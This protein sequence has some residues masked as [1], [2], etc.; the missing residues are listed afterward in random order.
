MQTLIFSFI[1]FLLG[2]GIAAMVAFFLLRRE[3]E[4]HELL[5]TREREFAA[6]TLAEQ[7]RRE[8][9]NRAERER[10]EAAAKTEREEQSRQQLE[11][12]KRE[13][14]ASSLRLMKE[15]QEELGKANTENVGKLI[16]PLQQEL[17]N[18]RKLM[19]ETRSANEKSTASL[20]G[21]LQE[22]LRKTAQISQD[23]TNL[24]DALKNRG[25][26]H[27]DWGEQVLEDILLGSGLREGDEYSTQQSYKG[28]HGNE[29]RPDVVIHCADGKHIIVDS[30]VSLT[31]YADALG[32]EGEEERKDAIRRN[33]ESVKKHVRELTEKNYPKYIEGSLNY[34]LMFIPN[35][36][37]Y[38]MAM[39]YDRAMAQEAFRK[40]VIIVNPTNLMLTLH[41]I[42][43]T[44]QQTRQE[45]NC[46]K[47]LDAAN[48]MYE[49]VIGVVDTCTS[50]GS[51]LATAGRTYD[52]LNK[53]LSEGTGNLLTRVD[54][55][56][57]LG[58]TSTKRPKVRKAIT[59][60]IVSAI[61]E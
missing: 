61:E 16:S 58:I 25:K 15:R 48:G 54:N 1:S 36:G 18:V 53:Q 40:G 59:N 32:A 50:L 9:E 21:A 49:K 27:G 5:L 23:A 29:L 41:L 31:A 33:C 11:L 52:T 37:A 3:R 17:E 39:N 43:Q 8:R 44:W 55:L 13:F 28:E 30:K 35:E 46:R 19:G 24:A 2:G 10:T 57:S 60:D 4:S 22:M 12:L 47:I 34:V 45:D 6:Q 42:L 51:Q 20:E 26:V 7:E 56:R 14:E 38:V